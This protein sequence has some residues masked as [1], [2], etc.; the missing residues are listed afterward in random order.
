MSGFGSPS[1]EELPLELLLR[2][3]QREIQD[4][5]GVVGLPS[6]LALHR[7]PTRDVFDRAAAL[8]GDSSPRR[9][10]L[11]V[12]ILRE[13][14]DEQADGRRPFTEE[15]VPL[16]LDRLRDEAEPSVTCWI[17]SALG[18]HRA[19]EALPRVAT[20]ADHPDER[21]RFH[22]AAA[23]PGLVDLDR[24]APE[25]AAALIR[26]CHDDDAETR[27]YALY[28]VTREIP[29]LDVEVVTRLTEQLAGD[30]DEQISAMAAAHHSAIGEVREL[31]GDALERGIATGAYDHL[32]GP[33]L[34]TLACAGDAGLLDE[35]VRRRLGAAAE[36]IHTARLAGDL[37]AWWTDKESR[38]T[39]D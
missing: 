18:Y 11:G 7:R 9:R 6:L 34:V 27:Y 35:E 5:D 29:S 17:V 31:L 4:D 39:W 28:A 20:L 13:L 3:A 32:I 21:V 33:V 8:T 15:T 1:Q 36:P 22:V 24:V 14:G 10:E 23:L 25:A 16:L 37:V 30:P 19:Q 38:I 12:R 2:L 26:L